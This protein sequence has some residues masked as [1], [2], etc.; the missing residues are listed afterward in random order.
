MTWRKL[1]CAFTFHTWRAMY[2]SA[3]HVKC[4]CEFCGAKRWIRSWP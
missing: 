2:M 1:L 4:R 3:G